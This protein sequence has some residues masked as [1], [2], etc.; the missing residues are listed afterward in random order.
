MSSYVQPRFIG[1][2]FMYDCLTSSIDLAPGT[3]PA[4]RYCTN[5]PLLASVQSGESRRLPGQMALQRMPCGAISRA[6]LCTRPMPPNFVAAYSE[7]A[8]LPFLP[9]LELIW[10]ITPFFCGFMT[11]QA[12]FIVRKLP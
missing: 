9:D 6:T 12:C 4:L 8:A 10:M 2:W 3:L 1:T 7:L 11:R 5:K